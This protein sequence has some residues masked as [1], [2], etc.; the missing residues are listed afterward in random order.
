MDKTLF[1]DVTIIGAGPV[2]SFVARAL[3]E[4]QI[5][6]A[7]IEQ[8]KTIGHPIN[9]AGLISSR[10]FETFHIPKDD[11][12]QNE[13]TTAHIHSPDDSILTIGGD[14]PH[15]YR[16]D[17]SKLDMFLADEAQKKGAK[18]FLGDKAFSIE[19]D[20]STI[21][22]ETSQKHHIQ[23]DI[24]VG[25]DG[26]YSRVRDV[27]GFPEPKEY[28]QGIGAQLNDTNLDGSSVEIFVGNKIAPGFFAWMIPTNQ[29]GTS[30]H[31]GLCVQKKSGISP[32]K[33]LQD[34]LTSP[35]TSDYLSNST[36][37]YH[38]G[39]IIPLGTLKQTVD[40]RVL[41]V[42]DAAAQVKPT[43][44]GGIY[45]GLLCAKHCANTILDSL[46]KQEYSSSQLQSY[47]NN[48]KQDIGKELSKGMYFRK[49]YTRLSDDLFDK[50]IKKLQQ[51]TVANIITEYGD[52]DYPSRLVKPLLKKTPS[53][54]RILTQL[55]V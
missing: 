3:S 47:H 33:Y 26:P 7:L 52:I 32:K 35:K 36:I 41:L 23:S 19:R 6:V 11:I 28:L 30:A 45:P 29:N 43:S 55:V 24:L 54:L 5:S 21:D 15:A 31:V 50:Y 48:W 16:I 53:L 39:G 22:I 2:G 42:G 34:F 17:R 44:G 38:T 46:E 37:E 20:P 8:H 27:F 13:I 18:L 51:D 9:C 4:H 14:K 49:I 1:Y 10:V 25:A 40:E 12:V